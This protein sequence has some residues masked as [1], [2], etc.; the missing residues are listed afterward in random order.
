MLTVTGSGSSRPSMSQPSPMMETGPQGITLVAIDGVEVGLAIED[1]PTAEVVATTHAA[2]T[3]AAMCLLPKRLN[4]VDFLGLASRDV[5]R[6]QEPHSPLMTR[7]AALT[8]HLLVHNVALFA[9]H[10]RGPDE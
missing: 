3:E 4:M 9:R 5:G 7:M 1:W 8:G 2:A 10:A 6:G